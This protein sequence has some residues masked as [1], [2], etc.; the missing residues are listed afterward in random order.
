MNKHLIAFGATLVI[1]ATQPTFAAST[2][3]LTVRGI[4]TP[5]A[6]ETQISGGGVID[7]GKM[8]VKELNA[9]Q[10]TLLPTQSLHLSVRCE[11]PTFFTLNTIDNRAGSSANH[12]NWHGL[13]MTPDGEKLG[14][15]AFNFY[16]RLADN[17]PVRTITSSDGGLTWTASNLLN[18]TVLTAV[19]QLDALEPIAV[20]QFGADIGLRAHI[21]PTD[22]LT[23]IDE[24]PV[25]G[26]ATL[27]L[28]Y[29]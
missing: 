22:S 27:Q 25:D 3:D 15:A 24:V 8:S 23:L 14:G 26:Y 16:N 29:L 5:S 11:G 7:F 12:P 10:H 1:T 6:C 13:G 19:A 4:I 17:V 21:A 9:D 20:R 18:H 28:K 2:Q